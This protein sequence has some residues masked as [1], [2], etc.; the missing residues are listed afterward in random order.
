MTITLVEESLMLTA[1]NR[2]SYK[3]GFACLNC[4]KQRIVC[5]M[6]FKEARMNRDPITGFKLGEPEKTPFP[7]DFRPDWIKVRET[8]DRLILSASGWRMVFAADE[9]E[10]S[11]TP[12]ITV[13][14]G[15]VAAAMAFIFIRFLKTYLSGGDAH[16]RTDSD[17]P[18]I[19]VGCDSRQT[20]PTIADIMLRVLLSQHSRVRYLFITA[21]PEIMAYTKRSDDIDGFIYISASHNPIGHNGVKF[22]LSDGAVIGGEKSKLLI[23]HLSEAIID[24]QNHQEI[25]QLLDSISFLNSTELETV[26]SHMPGWKESAKKVYH[27]FAREV[28]SGSSS[29]ELQQQ[30]FKNLRRNSTEE[31][32]GVVAELNGSARTLSIDQQILQ[33]A[34]IKTAIINGTPREIVHPIVPEGPSLNLCRDELEKRAEQD[35]A[36]LFG[37]VPDNDGDR[38]NIV[39]MDRAIGRANVLEAQQV[40]ALVCV[41]ELS[42][43]ISSGIPKEKIAVAV[44]GP[45]SLRIEAIAEA[46]QATVFRAEVGEA[47]VVALARKIRESGMTVRILGE[48]SNGGN[49]THPSTVRDP[50]NTLFA[51]LKLLLFRKGTV[52]DGS[53]SNSEKLKDL[54]GI[55]CTHSGQTDQYRE[56]YTLGDIISSLPRYSTT[57]IT[58]TRAKLEIKAGDHTELKRHYLSLFKQ[59]FPTIKQELYDKFKIVSWVPL[60]H[61]GVTTVE[62]EEAIETYFRDNGNLNG[63]LRILFKNRE[64]KAAAFVWMRG[65]G[66]EPVFRIL[67]DVEG[68][69][70]SKEKELLALHT[71]LIQEADS[72]F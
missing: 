33:E 3:M 23:D 67:A 63:G 6:C 68:D 8:F 47:N 58:E 15:I 61:A 64:E 54:F 46:F 71:R 18:T 53:P 38:G 12:S 62:G 50:L 36:F 13:E 44:N 21:A 34:G 28:I 16:S 19:V 7:P 14:S 35:R 52:R 40:F 10:E 66:T 20:G 17:Q 25:E 1:I 70:N 41:A 59:Q 4:T 22:G 51:L 65:S 55:W 27:S 69:D 30:F 24:S 60:L 29:K 5:S 9:K 45:T 32:I 37:Y 49:I 42:F 11:I 57:P 2:D 39:Y 56:D 43:L 72:A 31:P 26:Y 48:G